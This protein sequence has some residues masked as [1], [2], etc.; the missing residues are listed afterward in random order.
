VS[1]W[2][3]VNER[4]P[5][6]ATLVLVATQRGVK[7]AYRREVT[8]REHGGPWRVMGI[9]RGAEYVTYWMPLPEPP[10]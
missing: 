1:E 10:K 9:W 3:S 4:L 7:S 2:I 6:P 8:K 5:E